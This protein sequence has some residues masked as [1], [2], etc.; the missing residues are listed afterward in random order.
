[1][2]DTERF[3]TEVQNRLCL[4]NLKEKSYSDRPAKRRAWEEIAEI[5]LDEWETYDTK[6]K[7]ES[8]ADLQKKWKHL[9]D[10]YVRE[11]KKESD[12]RSGS[13]AAAKKRKTPYVEML[14]FLDVVREMRPT[15]SN[16]EDKFDETSGE[17][18]QLQETGSESS[19]S[20][21]KPGSRKT[22]SMT[23]FQRSLINSMEKSSQDDNDSDKQFL[24]SLLPQMKKC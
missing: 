19:N 24:L 14:R 15:T 22:Q 21:S 11:R 8:I 16:L 3:I 5:L 6:T 12:V 2:F 13:A 23:L 10:Y 7:N 17:E 20:N 9:R 4:W 18:N 1:M